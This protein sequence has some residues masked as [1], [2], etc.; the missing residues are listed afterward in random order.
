MKSYIDQEIC[1][2]CEHCIEVCPCNIL[3][4]DTQENVYFIPERQSICLKC[5][6][7]MAICTTK[8]ISIEGL[9][10]DKDFFE[11]PDISIDHKN[12]I[13]F[14]ANRRSIR[15]FKDKPVSDEVI[16]QILD[17]ISYA[18]FGA[19][20]EKVNI[21]VVN[22]RDKIESALPYIADFLDNIVKW[23]ENP[24]ASFMIK[25]RNSEETFSTIKN[26][27]YPIARLGNYKLEYGDRITRNAPAII[28]FHA[29]KNAEEYTH[30]SLIYATYMILSAH[31]LGL[32]A[33]MISLVPA[34][35]NK[36]KEVRGIFSI[37]EEHTAIISVIV[38]YP[39]YKFKRAIKRPVQVINYV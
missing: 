34:A 7:C 16:K 25:R 38:G 29:D 23:I 1:K 28:I 18:P 6:H 20:P 2:Q 8:A 39:K 31:S 22:N 10:Y 26:H 3:G 11:L 21:T 5:G 36:V 32:G 14:L 15:N 17:P 19:K 27:L 24:V 33:C 30:N 13:D 12:F 4:T 9:S 35:I 37:P